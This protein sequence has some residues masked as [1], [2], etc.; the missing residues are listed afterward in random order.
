M[1][2]T[3]PTI[4]STDIGDPMN[5]RRIDFHC[6]DRSQQSIEP[7]H[8]TRHGISTDLRG[9]RRTVLPEDV[10]DYIHFNLRDLSK[11]QKDNLG[12]LFMITGGIPVVS[13]RF[14]ELRLAQDLGATEF[15]E[16]PLLEY[17]Q[18]TRRP[19]RWFLL[20][21]IESKPTLIP[22][23]SDG[24]RETAAKGVFAP[25]SGVNDV[26]AVRATSAEGSDLWRDR[27]ILY[28]LF[29]SDRL[30]RAIKEAGIKVR[31]MPMCKC[32][33]VAAA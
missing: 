2:D 5:M 16:V 20:S 11:S 27:G 15:H 32:V 21:I 28:R 12:D 9:G 10:P 18:Q 4:W 23:K 13:E 31:R 24:I 30:K 7:L 25:I 19:G 22:E 14:R 33:V 26:L 1:P 29:L 17:D 8:V 3:L 6:P